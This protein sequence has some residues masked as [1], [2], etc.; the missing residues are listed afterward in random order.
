MS[1]SSTR[2]QRTLVSTEAT[3]T[4]LNG[5][6]TTVISLSCACIP[7]QMESRRPTRRTTFPQ[8]EKVSANLNGRRQRERIRD[9]DGLSG[10]DAEV[11]RKL[12]SSLQPGCLHAL[13]HRSVPRAD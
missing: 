2:R 1:A 12:F 11:S 6:G 4:I 9:G 10:F 13:L 3:R 7:A 5:R 8:A